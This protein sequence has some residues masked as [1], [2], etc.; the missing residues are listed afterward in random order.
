MGEVFVDTVH[1]LAL[2]NPRDQW[3]DQALD[4]A[5]G[6]TEPLV[7]TGAVLVEVADALC[8]PGHRNVATQVLTAVRED[9]DFTCV[10]V[11]AALFDRALTLYA[12]RVDKAWSL[13]DCVSFEVMR[14]RGIDR[15]LTANQHFV[16]AGFRA[17][18]LE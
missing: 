4:R 15:A 12:G 2:V 17:L 13:T 7:T 9:P 8:R 3:R 1:L 10:P 14:R 18:L 16:Q 11:D 6:V 5:A